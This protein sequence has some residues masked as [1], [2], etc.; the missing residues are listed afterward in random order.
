MKTKSRGQDKRQ[1]PRF[2]LEVPVTLRT[3]GKLIPA[4]SLNLSLGGICVL[5]DYNEKIAEGETEV[6]VDLPPNF[7]DVSLRGKILRH[8]KGI[9]QRVAIQFTKKSQAGQKTLQKFLSNSQLSTD[10]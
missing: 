7:H 4:A 3:K 5:T 2:E 6:V 10:D 8:E 9:G 1:H